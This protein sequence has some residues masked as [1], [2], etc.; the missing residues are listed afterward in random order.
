MIDQ[1]NNLYKEGKTQEAQ[2][3]FDKVGAINKEMQGSA[4]T[5]TAAPAL[6]IPTAESADAAVLVKK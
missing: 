6:E 4:P 2:E 3:L 1:A 5:E